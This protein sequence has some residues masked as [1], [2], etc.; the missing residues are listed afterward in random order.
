[1]KTELI[2]NNTKEI[3]FLLSND[4]YLYLLPREGFMSYQLVGRVTA[5]QG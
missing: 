3:M 4:G 1:M 5:Y 2:L